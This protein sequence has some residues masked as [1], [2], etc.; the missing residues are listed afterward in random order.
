MKVQRTVLAKQTF[1]GWSTDV[2]LA[3]VFAE[4]LPRTGKTLP[5]PRL[6]EGRLFG[7][8]A[9]LPLPID[10]RQPYDPCGTQSVQVAQP[11]RAAELPCPEGP[12]GQRRFA[13][14][15]L[16]PSGYVANRAG[17]LFSAPGIS[18]AIPSS[19]LA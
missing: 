11:C 9:K 6:H 17:A 18:A 19:R 16:R 5:I 7:D 1:P 8:S 10:S 4:F 14:L 15:A 12:R 13:A 3:Y 2:Y